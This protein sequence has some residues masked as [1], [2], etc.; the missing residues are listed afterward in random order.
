QAGPA[1]PKSCRVL[2]GQRELFGGE[3]MGQLRLPALGLEVCGRGVRPGLLP[4]LVLQGLQG[5]P[6]GLSG[7]WTAGRGW[8]GA[9]A[10]DRCDGGPVHL[11][12]SE[13]RGLRKPKVQLQCHPGASQ[14]HAQAGERPALREAEAPQG[15]LDRGEKRPLS[16]AGA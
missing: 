16:R 15:W 3:R 9:V 14:A 1:A 13:R 2:R 10:A 11:E 8:K 5:G 7:C 12:L 6:E 4:H